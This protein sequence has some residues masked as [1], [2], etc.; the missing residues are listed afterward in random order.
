MTWEAGWHY[1][2]SNLLLSR[3]SGCLIHRICRTYKEE[4]YL[5]WRASA[6]YP[7]WGACTTKSSKFFYVLWLLCCHLK[8]LVYYYREM[9]GNGLT[10]VLT[11]GLT[12]KEW[13]NPTVGTVTRLLKTDNF[14]RGCLNAIGNSVLLKRMWYI[15]TDFCFVCI[16]CH[17]TKYNDD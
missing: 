12:D 4:K 15:H 14:L 3:W 17:A 10:P 6:W 16:W 11:E 2:L 5:C 8:H 7:D 9:F 1:A 13:D